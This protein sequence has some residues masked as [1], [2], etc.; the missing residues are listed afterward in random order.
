MGLLLLQ[1]CAQDVATDGPVRGEGRDTGGRGDTG[2]PQ[3]PDVG[4]E[5]DVAVP[6][7]T[8][9][10]DTGVP[11]PDGG[12]QDAGQDI[13]PGD[14]TLVPA[15]VNPGDDG[16]LT[17]VGTDSTPPDTTVPDVAAPDV[18][19]DVVPDGPCTNGSTRVC[20]DSAVQANP[21]L[22]GVGVCTAGSQ[23]CT[24]TSWGPCAGA[25]AP[26]AEVCDNL[27]NNCNGFVD[28][29]V[30]SRVCASACGEGSEI[31]TAGTWGSCSAPT[32]AP[33]EICGDGADNDCNGLV[34]DGCPSACGRVRTR[35]GL[36]AISSP[37]G[38]ID[39][40][41]QIADVARGAGLTVVREGLVTASELANYDVLLMR[42]NSWNT[43]AV[44]GDAAA[45]SSA[46]ADWVRAGGALMVWGSSFLTSTCGLNEPWTRDLPVQFVCGETRLVQGGV[47]LT[48]HPINSGMT[49]FAAFFG[50]GYATRSAVGPSAVTANVNVSG[51]ERE[52]GRAAEMGCGKVFFWG[53]ERTTRAENFPQVLPFWQAT[54]GWL[55]R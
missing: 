14:D 55:V 1:G 23:T 28:E 50:D 42:L 51:T 31:C 52:V 53:S 54:I 43:D 6:G 39:A 36:Y 10:A 9:A 3:R 25:G 30:P 13:A 37:S 12:T 45:F 32:P 35:V 34:D 46:L 38:G 11:L 40:Y 2:T 5:A 4:G 19:P 49:A 18:P 41:E 47:S 20:Y 16:A 7:D 8:S 15:D 26:S 44:A 33:A 29:G 27:D 17:D 22:R 21:A 24:G 48:T